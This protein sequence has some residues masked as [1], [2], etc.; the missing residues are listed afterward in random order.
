MLLVSRTDWITCGSVDQQN[1]TRNYFGPYRG[2]IDVTIFP[3]PLERPTPRT[4]DEGPEVVAAEGRARIRA[5]Q[6]VTG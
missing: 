4:T 1:S 3:G 2:R 5:L 6:A